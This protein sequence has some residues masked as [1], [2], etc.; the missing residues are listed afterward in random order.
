MDVRCEVCVRNLVADGVHLLY[1]G[2]LGLQKVKRNRL[3]VRVD[4]VGR[5]WP[6]R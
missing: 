3:D 1:E 4:L 6:S 5:T 2:F